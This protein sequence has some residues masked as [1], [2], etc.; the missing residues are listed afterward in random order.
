[1]SQV[2]SIEKYLYK[3]LKFIL[4]DL[5]N[6]IAIKTFINKDDKNPGIKESFLYIE[7]MCKKDSFI[8]KNFDNKAILIAINKDDKEE[9]LIMNHIDTVGI[10]QKEKWQSNPF[11]LTRKNSQFFA[12]GVNDNKGPFIFSYWILKYI[13]NYFKNIPINVKIFLGSA[14]ETSWEGISHYKTKT[15]EPKY[16]IS[17]D[18]N[19]P[20]TNIERGILKLELSKK[21]EEMLTKQINVSSN[22][23]FDFLINDISLVNLNGDSRK[24]ISK[25]IKSRNPHQNINKTALDQLISHLE[26]EW[27]NIPNEFIFIK[28]NLLNGYIY[29]LLKINPKEKDETLAVTA[30]SMNNNFIKIWLDIRYENEKYKNKLLSNLEKESWKVDIKQTREAHIVP[31]DN[32]LVTELMKAYNDVCKTN[33]KP[34]KFSGASYARMFENAVA[35]GTTFSNEEVNSHMPNE[36]IDIKKI[37]L[38]S[39]IIFN[40]IKNIIKIE[41][42]ILNERF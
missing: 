41:R 16:A 31:N 32:N 13:K 2:I 11:K 8:F 34:L 22:E 19:F 5:S 3:N 26:K 4:K 35:F 28:T 20:L 14:E 10:Y 12:R 37:I 9:F 23:S 38:S 39:R 6:L 7:K 18:G 27:H 29:N 25:K 21:I 15:K 33:I 24:F 40:G 42:K 36:N 30:F 17:P 1:M